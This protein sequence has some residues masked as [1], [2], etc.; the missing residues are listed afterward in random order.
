M[1]NTKNS[2]T[3]NFLVQAA[4]V[5]T[6]IENTP[7]ALNLLVR[8]GFAAQQLPEGRQML[9]EA[10]SALLEAEDFSLD[11]K[12]ATQQFNAE[13]KSLAT[14]HQIHLQAA[15]RCLAKEIPHLLRSRPQDF[16]GWV[17]EAQRFYAVILNKAEYLEKLN[18]NSIPAEALV[19]ANQRLAVLVSIKNQQNQS[20]YNTRSNTESKVMKIEEFKGWYGAMIALAR[21]A[22][23]GQPALRQ[24]LRTSTPRPIS[25]IKLPP[26]VAN[27]SPSAAQAVIA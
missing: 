15:R 14:V 4:Q 7:Q 26:P 6:A 18:A 11:Q 25:E 5:L 23:R 17:S 12:K 21:V 13:W 16:T 24:I 1:T 2:P 8:H 10:K 9:E 27:M 22:F 3:L 19:S 20:Q